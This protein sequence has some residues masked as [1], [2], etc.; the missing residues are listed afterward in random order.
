MADEGWR[1]LPD[2]APEL[3]ELLFALHADPRPLVDA[4]AS[5]P[6]TFLQGD[7]KMGNLGVAPRRSDDPARLGL[8]G[9]GAVLLGPRLVPRPQRGPGCRCR[10][11]TPSRRSAD[12]LEA[13][14]VATRGWFDE[15]VALCL[16]AITVTFGWEKA[17]GDE[18]ELRWWERVALD[19][20]AR[21]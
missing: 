18:G 4:L 2:R 3:A 10:R 12:A 20:A 5:T 16:L 17:V 8:P 14:G 11:R 21:L 19:G 7:W 9:R 1:R 15:Q 6:S 13:R